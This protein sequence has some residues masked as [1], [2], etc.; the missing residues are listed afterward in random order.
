M[1]VIWGWGGRVMLLLLR[2]LGLIGIGGR[3]LVFYK[4]IDAFR[5]SIFLVYAIHFPLASFDMAIMALLE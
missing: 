1:W 2:L 4:T 3:F 5:D